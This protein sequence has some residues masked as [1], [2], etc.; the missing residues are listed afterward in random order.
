MQEYSRIVIE[1]YC[2][3]HNSAKSKRLEKLVEMSYDMS[4]EGTDDDAIFLDSAFISPSL[5]P[6]RNFGKPCRIW[7]IICSGIETRF[8]Y[9]VDTFIMSGISSVDMIERGMLAPIRIRL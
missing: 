1:E 9:G 5:M 6:A 3:T 8:I 2:S 4:A 7:T